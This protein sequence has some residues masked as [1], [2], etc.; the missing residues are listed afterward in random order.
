[1]ARPELGTKYTC[2]SCEAK[3]YDLNR[4]PFSCPKCGE[5]YAAPPVS[6]AEVKKSKPVPAAKAAKPVEVPA[7]K[8][9]ADEP[10][11]KIA[12]EADIDEELLA[13]VEIDDD[14]DDEAADTGVLIV[15]DDDNDSVSGIVPG[16]KPDKEGT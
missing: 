6:P 7:A 4:T 1:M 10:A 13:A 15:D 11:D 8:V 16:G 3:F 9:V 5:V 2:T 12:D 14:D